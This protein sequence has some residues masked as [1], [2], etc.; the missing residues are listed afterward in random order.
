MCLIQILHLKIFPNLNIY[1]RFTTLNFWIFDSAS[2][3]LFIA[4]KF[5]VHIKGYDLSFFHQTFRHLRVFRKWHSLYTVMYIYLDDSSI[6]SLN[7]YILY[8]YSI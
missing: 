3:F 4:I 8:A 1:K 7:I 5:N 2:Y 6:Y